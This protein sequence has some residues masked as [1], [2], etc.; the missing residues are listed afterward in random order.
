LVHACAKEINE[1]GYLKWFQFLSLFSVYCFY[2][3]DILCESNSWLIRK[4]LRV[5]V[6]FFNDFGD[7]T[8]K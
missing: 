7:A 1:S 6:P 4:G 8:K 2:S 3:T 5:W